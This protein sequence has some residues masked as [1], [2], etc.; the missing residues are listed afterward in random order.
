VGIDMSPEPVNRA[1][2][3]LTQVADAIKKR[4]KAL[5][6]SSEQ[7]ARGNAGWR[8]ADP[9]R[10][11]RQAWEGQV[12]CLIDQTHNAAERLKTSA[13]NVAASDQEAE[14]RLQQVLRDLTSN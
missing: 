4:I 3:D 8:S 9:L 2:D 13:G 1:G 11:C 14:N 5:F 10:R 6:D 7:A 12:D